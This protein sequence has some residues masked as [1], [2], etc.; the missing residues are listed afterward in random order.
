ML[1][2]Q[3]PYTSSHKLII[4][5]SIMRMTKILSSQVQKKVPV[6]GDITSPVKSLL[7]MLVRYWF[8]C[9]LCL[10]SS[11]Y[12]FKKHCSCGHGHPAQLSLL[13]HEGLQ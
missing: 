5:T 9:I 6:L 11:L 1:K 8:L 4:H 7:A 12:L 13:T 3:H 2:H 10:G